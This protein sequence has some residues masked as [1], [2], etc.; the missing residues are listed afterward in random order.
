MVFYFYAY[1]WFCSYSYR[2]P[3][4]HSSGRWSSATN[5]KTIIFTTRCCSKTTKDLLSHF[6]S[7]QYP[8]RYRQRLRLNTL[9]VTNTALLTP[10]SYD[11][12]ACLFFFL[13]G[14]GGGENRSVNIPSGIALKNKRNPFLSVSSSVWNV[15]T[16]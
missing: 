3:L 8:K 12:H 14:G 4:S 9:R 1:M 6:F 13:E 2:A 5:T 11:E 16:A 15:S 7:A 10:K